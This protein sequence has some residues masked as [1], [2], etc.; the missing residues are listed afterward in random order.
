MILSI[1]TIN[2]DNKSG[3]QR[4]LNSLKNQINDQ[5]ELIIIDGASKDGSLDVVEEYKSIIHT[6]ISEKDSGIYNAMNKGVHLAKGD[7]IY[8]LNS[9]DIWNNKTSLSDLIKDLK[10]TDFILCSSIWRYNSFL[11]LT[12]RLPALMNKYDLYDGVCHQST[13]V[14]TN[15]LKEEQFNETDLTADWQFLFKKIYINN[16]TYGIINKSVAIYDLN[17]ISSDFKTQDRIK[18]EKQRFLKEHSINWNKGKYYLYCLRSRLILKK[19][20]MIGI[21]Q[22]QKIKRN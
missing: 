17:G 18:R 14:R 5:V 16:A 22:I 1:I 12:E 19:L 6:H 2:K 10:N 21:W 20:F 3:L 15:L 11:K 13:F 9:G 4:T 8:F 7:Y